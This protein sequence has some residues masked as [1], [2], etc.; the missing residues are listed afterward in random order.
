MTPFSLHPQLDAD[1]H[2]VADLPLCTVRLMND[3]R[4]P[5][6]V[7]IPRRDA[8]REIYELDSSAQQQLWQETTQLG[9]LLM[10]VSGGEKL[11]IGAL[12]NMVPQLH[13]HVIARR[14]DDA[15]WP[16]PVWGVGTAEPHD[17]EALTVL[18]DTLRMK[19]AELPSYSY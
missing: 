16:G 12:G 11:N 6:L 8:I 2:F 7:L 17:S 14:S 9:E 13:M 19:I 3:A 5:W 18:V 1:T 10:T 15:A 4:Y